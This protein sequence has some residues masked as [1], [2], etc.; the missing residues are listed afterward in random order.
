MNEAAARQGENFAVGAPDWNDR[1]AETPFQTGASMA[2]T[3]PLRPRMIED[4]TVRNFSP[5]TQRS[6]VHAV[7]P[8]FDRSPETLTLEDVRTY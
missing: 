7:Q 1:V 3:S 8:V 6:Y 4:M 2:E 5:A